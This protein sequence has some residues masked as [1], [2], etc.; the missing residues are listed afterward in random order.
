[1]DEICADYK[2][3]TQRFRDFCKN[4]S[5]QHV[6]EQSKADQIAADRYKTAMN[7]TWRHA[8]FF[9]TTNG[10]IGVGLE[11][12][13]PGD[14]ICTVFAAHAPFISRKNAGPEAYAFHG[15]TYVHGL[16]DGEAFTAK[17]P[18]SNTQELVVR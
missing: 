7:I 13:E 14:D 3:A 15:E 16:M 12:I 2:L 11:T 9:T 5:D 1:M 6:T 10:T 18:V 4:P 17:D 8:N